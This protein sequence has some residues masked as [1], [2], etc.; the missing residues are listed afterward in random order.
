MEGTYPAPSS[1]W[2]ELS[3][4]P[5]SSLLTSRPRYLIGDHMD[6]MTFRDFSV[7][8]FLMQSGVVALPNKGLRS[9]VEM[10]TWMLVCVNRKDRV[11]P[12]LCP[13]SLSSI[14]VPNLSR[15]PLMLA[16]PQSPD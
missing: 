11:P 16:P 6:K 13:G 12:D 9:H 14:S 1:P 2:A 8:L 4:R 15:S 7:L 10:T 5:L 3:A